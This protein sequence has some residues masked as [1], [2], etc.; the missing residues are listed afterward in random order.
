MFMLKLNKIGD[1]KSVLKLID[2]ANK[3]VRNLKI[4]ELK[5]N[6]LTDYI[7]IK[8]LLNKLDNTHSIIQS[9]SLCEKCLRIN[10]NVQNF[11]I[12]IK[13]KLCRLPCHSSLHA[14]TQ[15]SANQ[16]NANVSKSV[17][18]SS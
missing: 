17:S 8:F 11:R 18:N 10:H 1:S 2:T 13:C 6:L 3:S 4:L 15:N 12:S 5:S 14:L 16:I 7:F 9:K